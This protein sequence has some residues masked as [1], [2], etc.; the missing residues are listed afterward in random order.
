[1]GDATGLRQAQTILAVRTPGRGLHDISRQVNDWCAGT[2]ILT[3]LLTVFIRHTSAAL[4]IQENADP[5]VLHD[6]EGFMTRLV[7]DDTALY[8]HVAEGADDMPAHIRGALTA[9][10]LSVPVAGGA[11]LFGTWQGLYLWE[12]RTRAH[13]RQVALHM[14][15]E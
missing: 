5:D 15:G 9:T 14:I 13:R 10:S 11:P 3:G 12:H 4:T 1:M 7:P 8:R 6:L 2:G